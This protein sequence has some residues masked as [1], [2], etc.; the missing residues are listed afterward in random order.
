[1]KTA[2][3]T[4]AALLVS[5]AAF[6]VDCPPGAKSCRVVV[7]TPEEAETLTG[8]NG[9]FPIAVWANRAGMTDLT[10]AWK[11]KISESPAGEVKA[12]PAPPTPAPAKGSK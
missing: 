2:A 4:I 8:Q 11:K 10:E 6:A 3:I 9:I 12:D 1:M 7:I 5:T